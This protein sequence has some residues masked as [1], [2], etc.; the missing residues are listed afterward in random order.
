MAS[1]KITLK[2]TEL[3]GLSLAE[4]EH[5]LSSILF[6]VLGASITETDLEALSDAVAKCVKETLMPLNDARMEDERKSSQN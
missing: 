6:A 2:L 5:K 4:E 1:E 3:I